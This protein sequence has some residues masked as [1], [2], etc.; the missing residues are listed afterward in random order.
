MQSI[1]DDIARAKNIV[2]VGGGPSGTEVAA[3]IV[4]AYAG[5]QVRG[6]LT[7]GPDLLLWLCCCEQLCKILIMWPRPLGASII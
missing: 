4:E 7:A 3:E 6:C 1:H 2:V 5:K